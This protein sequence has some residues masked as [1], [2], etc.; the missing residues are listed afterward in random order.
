MSGTHYHDD[1]RSSDGTNPAMGIFLLLILL[2]FLF[3]VGLPSFMPTSSQA[4][5]T[6]TIVQGR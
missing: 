5:A 1:E 3:L 4:Q 6:P 2:A